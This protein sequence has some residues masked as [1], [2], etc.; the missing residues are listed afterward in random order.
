MTNK[1]M[2]NSR[3]SLPQLRKILMKNESIFNQNVTISE[4]VY[5]DGNELVKGNIVIVPE[6][7]SA[8][9]N[10]QNITVGTPENKK[11]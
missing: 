5:L 3:S 8:K 1:N 6:P 11:T 7:E 10:E 4:P 9:K 2:T